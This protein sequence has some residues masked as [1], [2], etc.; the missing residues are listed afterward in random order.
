MNPLTLAGAVFLCAFAVV[1]AIALPCAG[2]L[3][4][5]ALL[6][7]RRAA[8]EAIRRGAREV[9]DQRRGATPRARDELARELVPSGECGA[10]GLCTC[11][12]C[13]A[14]LEAGLRWLESLPPVRADAPPAHPLSWPVVLVR[15]TWCAVERQ[16]WTWGPTFHAVER[17]SARELGWIRLGTGGETLAIDARR[18][19]ERAA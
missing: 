10:P 5:V 9:L 16:D 12:R 11:A 13:A 1:M 17:Y 4:V 18:E 2:A 7:E 19:A 15:G 6:T 14:A 3:A 8:R